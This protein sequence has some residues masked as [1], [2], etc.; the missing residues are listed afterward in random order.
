MSSG[1][2]PN[3]ILYIVNKKPKPLVFGPTVET[4]WYHYKNIIDIKNNI[5]NVSVQY[6][7]LGLV[8]IMLKANGTSI[9][10]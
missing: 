10:C 4:I 6:I 5:N 3:T 2:K 7:Y 9:E 1:L 8:G